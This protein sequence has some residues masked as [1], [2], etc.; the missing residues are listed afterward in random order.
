[1]ELVDSTDL[2]TLDWHFD[3]LE[4]KQN[5][6]LEWIVLHCSCQIQT[7]F[8]FRKIANRGN[9]EFYFYLYFYFYMIELQE[10]EKPI[11]AIIDT[12]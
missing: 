2:I 6:Y 10:A 5:L 1:M 11:F 4:K 8:N 3:A 9:E 7:F 12:L